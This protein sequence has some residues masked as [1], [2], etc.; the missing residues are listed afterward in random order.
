MFVRAGWTEAAEVATP[1]TEG[2]TLDEIFAAVKATGEWSETTSVYGGQ[3]LKYKDTYAGNIVLEMY[4]AASGKVMT[5]T[6]YEQTIEGQGLTDYSAYKYAGRK[7]AKAVLDI[8]HPTQ[9]DNAYM[10]MKSVLL[11]EAYE[12]GGSQYPSVLRWYDGRVFLC[13]TNGASHCMTISIRELND[14]EAYN[15]YKSVIRSSSPLYYSSYAGGRDND[16]AAFEL[17]KW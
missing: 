11:Q 12:Y 6:L 3:A 13:R 2:K 5:L 10:G 9:S 16:V 7:V 17:D 8:A 1:V 15:T 14:E 4:Q